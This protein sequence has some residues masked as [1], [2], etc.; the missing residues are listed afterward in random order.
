M[1]HLLPSRL[2]QGPDH[3]GPGPV[4]VIQHFLD[5]PALN[6]RPPDHLREDR[7]PLPPRTVQSAQTAEQPLTLG[8]VALPVCL[9]CQPNQLLQLQNSSDAALKT[10]GGAFRSTCICTTY[11]YFWLGVPDLIFF[12]RTATGMLWKRLRNFEASSGSSVTRPSG[13]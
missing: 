11:E 10:S 5:H 8:H 13:V 12:T 4:D 2:L 9:P 6:S 7:L 1:L 3:L